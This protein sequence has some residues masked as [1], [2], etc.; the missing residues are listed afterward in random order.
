MRAEWTWRAYL[1]S[2]RLVQVLQDW[3]TPPPTSTPCTCSGTANY[4]VRASWTS[5]P[6]TSQRFHA[7]SLGS[8]QK[9]YTKSCAL[10]L[11]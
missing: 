6:S 5:W 11:I 9:L 4:R 2:G 3:Q 8:S 7:E 10:G 1:R